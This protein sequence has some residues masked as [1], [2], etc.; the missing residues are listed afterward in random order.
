MSIQN[1][2]FGLVPPDP[3]TA[4]DIDQP[5]IASS[6]QRSLR[7]TDYANAAS[8]GVMVGATT[9]A[10]AWFV[11]FGLSE[12]ISPSNLVSQV[13]ISSET[14]A[15]FVVLGVIGGGFWAERRLLDKD[16]TD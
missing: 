7:W 13:L 2:E 14:K 11:C 16:L 5:S 15:L 6:E 1:I 8:L 9:G 10:W 12:Y 4:T 3:D